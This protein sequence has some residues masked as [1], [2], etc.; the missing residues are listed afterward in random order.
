M[1]QA[2]KTRVPT[3]QMFGSIVH[4]IFNCFRHLLFFGK[5]VLNQLTP[6]RRVH[7]EDI[8]LDGKIILKWIL[9]QWSEN[10]WTALN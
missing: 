3:V 9:E 1:L 8:G 5:E 4:F 10:V 2:D 7:F 6:W